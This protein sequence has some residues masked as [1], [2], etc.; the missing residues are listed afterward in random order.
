MEIWSEKKVFIE[1]KMFLIAQFPT[2]TSHCALL[3]NI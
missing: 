2:I 1:T 3:K